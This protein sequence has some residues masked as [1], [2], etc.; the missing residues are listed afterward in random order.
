MYLFGSLATIATLDNVPDRCISRSMN[1]TYD[2][3]IIGAGLNGTTM[4]LGAAQFGLNVALFDAHKMTDQLEAGFDGRSYALSLTS[5][6]MMRSLSLWDTLEE[7]AQPMLDIKV[8]EGQL[9]DGPSPFFLHF[10]HNE[11][12]EGPMG[13]MVQDRYLRPALQ[14]A[15]D[16]NNQVDYYPNVKI[17]SHQC[18]S[19]F[20]SVITDAGQE[21]TGKLLIAADGRQSTTATRAGICRKGWDYGQSA[22]VCAIEHENSH[23]ATAYQYLMPQGPLAILPL[24]KNRSSIVWSE[25]HERAKDI[26][27]LD[28]AAYLSV[29]RPRFG[30]FLGD[31]KLAGKRYKYPLSLSIAEKFVKPR[32]ALIG[33]AAHG[34][35]PIAGQGLNAGLKDIAAL[36]HVLQ[37]AHK[38]GENIGAIDVLE[39]YQEWRRFDV[40]LLALATDGFN[41]LFSNSNALLRAGRALGLGLINQMPKLRRSFIREAAGIGTSD[42][43]Y[44]MR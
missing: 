24:T 18:T 9:P 19:E 15:V 21:Y 25:T 7:Y 44:L 8:C 37:D 10:D 32:V 29:L 38:R 3:L 12:E 13:H 16:E 11:I 26:M 40:N 31:I 14:R 27:Q 1:K 2:I 33:D 34:I 36:C 22:L 39:R 23:N 43:P 6:R 30:D 4:A 42:L 5:V 35:H 20:V 28:D 17:Q 41:K